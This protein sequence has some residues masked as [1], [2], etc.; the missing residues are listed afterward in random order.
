LTPVE[1]VT[2][3]SVAFAVAVPAADRLLADVVI[4]FK[5]KPSR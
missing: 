2:V 5:G 3:S 1:A 4:V